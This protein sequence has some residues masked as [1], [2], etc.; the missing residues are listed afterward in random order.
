MATD[1]RTT[2]K[3]TPR[4]ASKDQLLKRVLDAELAY[5]RRRVELGYELEQA[6]LRRNAVMSAA[7]DEGLT[8]REIAHALGI[9]FQRIHQI[10]GASR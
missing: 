6:R 2:Q 10:I 7:A 5:R 4:G 8:L 3:Q 1:S 9:S